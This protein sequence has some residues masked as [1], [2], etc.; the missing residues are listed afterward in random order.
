M[1]KIIALF[2]Q[3]GLTS[4]IIQTCLLAAILYLI[5]LIILR[6]G[7]KRFLG[8]SAAFDIVLGIIIG[9]VISRAINGTAK[10]FPTI[11]AIIILVV[12]HWVFA[13]LSLYSERI[14]LIIK[15]KSSLIVKDGKILPEQMKKNQI[16]KNDLMMHLRLDGRLTDIK[17]VKE[18]YHEKGGRVSIIPKNTEPKIIDIEVK[19]GVQVV[20]ILLD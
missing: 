6:F 17:N 9:S 11:A 19:E 10:L 18:A 2:S 1:S 7:D 12:M 4:E 14:S 13:I 16:S 5:A 20:R 15:G 8:K 3:L